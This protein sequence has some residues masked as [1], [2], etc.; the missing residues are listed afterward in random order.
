MRIVLLEAAVV[1]GL[2]G[3]LGYLAGLAAS[4]VAFFFFTE[5]KSL[6]IPMDLNLAGA[7]FGLA[8]LVGLVSSAYP[9]VLA[10][11]LDPNEA[12]RTL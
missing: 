4:Q 5:G 10:A 12:L 8:L 9:A 2:A 7:A 1:S 11:R 6:S 3:I